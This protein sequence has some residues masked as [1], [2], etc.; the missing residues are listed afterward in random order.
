MKSRGSHQFT[1]SMS[2]LFPAR[3]RDFLRALR[4][5]REAAGLTQEDVAQRLNLADQ[6]IVSKVERGARRLDFIEALA[7]LKVLSVDPG[8]FVADILARN[9]ALRV[10]GGRR[11]ESTPAPLQ[12]SIDAAYL[13]KQ[14]G[15]TWSGRGRRP[16]WLKAAIQSGRDLREFEV[17][18]DDK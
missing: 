18:D 10:V 2:T 11:G 4:E 9:E 8:A 13:D 16:M 3:Y 5:A 1:P 12:Q 6:S 17:R 15:K 7:W 14:S